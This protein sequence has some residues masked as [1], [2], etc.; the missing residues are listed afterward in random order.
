MKKFLASLAL[1]ACLTTLLLTNIYQPAALAL[2]ESSSE[3]AGEVHQHQSGADYAYWHFSGLDSTF[4]NV[5]QYI[6]VQQKAPTTFW[7]MQVFFADSNDAGYMGLQQRAA[8]EGDIA[9][10]SLWNANAA[11]GSSCGTFG[12]EGVGYSCRMPFDVIE[13]NW[14]RLR[15]W[16]MET[17]GANQWWGAWIYSYNTNTDYY[18]GSIRVPA[19]GH[20]TINGV[21]NFSEYWGQSVDCDKVPLSLVNLTQPAAN[22]NGDEV[23][24]YR[25]YSQ[26][27]GWG[28]ASCTGGYAQDQDFGF[29]KGVSL[30][31][32][33]DQNVNQVIQP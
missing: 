5:D 16:R 7:A 28:K 15:L 18:V 6:Q 14:Y 20:S 31:L 12:G 33:G 9:I 30:V 10:F 32:G 23:G 29:T 27:S 26:S 21:L 13:G 19:K 22:S 8:G 25:N 24:T 17:E 1:T 2:A 11:R 3:E 4:W